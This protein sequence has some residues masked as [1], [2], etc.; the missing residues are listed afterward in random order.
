MQFKSSTFNYS[1]FTLLG[2]I[3]A[4]VGQEREYIWKAV[5]G[6]WNICDNLNNNGERHLI[7]V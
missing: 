1:R 2:D 4:R 3:N 6:R 7:F 5:R